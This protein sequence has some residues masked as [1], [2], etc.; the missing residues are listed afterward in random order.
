MP[1]LSSHVRDAAPNQIREITQAAWAQPDSIVLSIGEPGFP[2][3]PHILEAAQATLGRDETGYTPNAGI[4]PLRAAFADRISRQTGTEVSPGRAFV[5][6]GAQQGLHLAMSMLLDAGDEIL[7][8]NPGY[9]TFAMTARLLHA[10]PVEYPLYPEHDFQPRIEDIEALITEK[11]RVLLLNS[12][13][14]PLGAVFSAG[15]VRDLVELARRRDLWI[16]SDECYEAFTYD[17]P[18]VSPLAYDGGPGGE[19]VI[20]SVTLSKTYGLTG[21]RIGALITPA[22]LEA[23]MSIAMEAIVSCVASPSQYAAL[24][25]LT[26]PQDYVSAA[27]AHYRTNRDAASAVLDAKSIPYLKAQ[28][29]FYLWADL[30][31]ASDGNVRAWTQKFLAEQGVAVA[32]GTA[33]GSIGEGWIRIALCGDAVELVTGLGRLPARDS[34]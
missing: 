22:G 3:P 5:T 28:G 20:V 1:E 33:F 11:T 13:S 24:A 4:A 7:I 8:P 23:P 21:L 12:P 18:H 19:R 30:S 2:T 32:P 27:A 14:N 16:I 25:A 15:L 31:H 10:E 29:A 34:G 9:P 6:S 26:G 17:V